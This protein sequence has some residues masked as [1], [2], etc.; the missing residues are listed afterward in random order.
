MNL[1]TVKRLHDAE[2]ACRE[3]QTFCAGVSREAFLADRGLNLI[4]QKL[5]EIVGEALRQAERSEPE[6][7][8]RIPDLRRI[9]NTRNRIIHGYESVD[10]GLL[11]DVA[12]MRIPA[13]QGTI[14]RI[15]ETEGEW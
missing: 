4:V 7:A 10:F 9:V 3:I 14:T 1:E 13:L 15:L 8:E 5:I 2:L 6:I 12:Q 11:W